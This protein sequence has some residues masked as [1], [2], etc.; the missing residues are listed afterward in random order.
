MQC[1]SGHHKLTGTDHAMRTNW[2]SPDASF[3]WLQ[4]YRF[5]PPGN[6]HISP[7]CS[8]CLSRW[9]SGF[10]VWWDMSVF[11]ISHQSS[12][13]IFQLVVLLRNSLRPRDNN[14]LKEVFCATCWVVPPPSNS[15]HQDYYILSRGFQPKPSF[16]TG[17]LGG[18]T[19]QATCGS[20]PTTKN[21]P[22]TSWYILIWNLQFQSCKS[23]SNHI[24]LEWKKSLPLANGPSLVGGWTTHLKNM[25]KSNWIISPR[26]GVKIQNV[27]N[28]TFI[29]WYEASSRAIARQTPQPE[30][31]F[32]TT[33]YKV[34]P[35]KL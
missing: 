34:G 35:Y 21:N 7:W 33:T 27:W 19:T 4:R 31:M 22:S 12:I 2:P 6:D 11:Q 15:H 5:D 16:A 25:R 14:N 9:F 28:H 17:I 20:S 8:A 26:F 23:S 1:I 29:M 24:I 10:P 3:K 13:G 30:K 18:G 32:E